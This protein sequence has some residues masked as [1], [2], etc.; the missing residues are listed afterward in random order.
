[1]TEKDNSFATVR[2]SFIAEFADSFCKV[3]NEI[4]NTPSHISELD[5]YKD[6]DLDSQS[7]KLDTSK[8]YDKR[9]E[10]LKVIKNGSIINIL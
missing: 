6:I 5:K 7:L 9:A 10:K 4:R 1:M 8:A 3:V 2:E